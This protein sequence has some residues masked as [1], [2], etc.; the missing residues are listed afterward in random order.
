MTVRLLCRQPLHIGGTL[1]LSGAGV[2]R[3]GRTS[4]SKKPGPESSDSLRWQ[5]WPSAQGC[6]GLKDRAPTRAPYGNVS[7]NLWNRPL[8][9]AAAASNRTR[10]DSRSGWHSKPS[11]CGRRALAECSGQA[12]RESDSRSPNPRAHRKRFAGCRGQASIPPSWLSAWPSTSP[13]QPPAKDPWLSLAAS[14]PARTPALR[15]SQAAPA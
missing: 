8:P 5:S 12:W 11:H 2:R 13:H 15:W 9:M 6:P 3:P 14:P 10:V 1:P 4:P 7:S